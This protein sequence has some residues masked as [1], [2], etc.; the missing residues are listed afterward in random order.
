MRESPPFVDWAED[1]SAS[2]AVSP[3]SLKSSCV[4]F[5]SLTDAITSTFDITNYDHLS[6]MTTCIQSYFPIMDESVR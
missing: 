2:V 5:F 6:R 1:G 3:A 4:D